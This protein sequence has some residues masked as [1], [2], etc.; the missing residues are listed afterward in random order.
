[1]KLFNYLKS[2]FL[3]KKTENQAS[4]VPK[5]LKIARVFFSIGHGDKNNKGVFDGGCEH[6]DIVEYQYNK[7][8]A[9]L[10]EVEYVLRY[11]RGITGV[12]RE[13]ERLK[14]DL[15]IELHLNSSDNPEAN[16]FEVLY[17]KG[18]KL[19]EAVARDVVIIFKSFF[20]HIKLRRN[21]GLYPVTDENG[22]YSL[23]KIVEHTKKPAIL[24]EGFFL[25]HKNDF[26]SHAQY[27][28]FLRELNQYFIGKEYN[29]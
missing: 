29:V 24:I 6:F 14:T 21:N 3:K 15:S 8:S 19:S 23:A 28:E 5:S 17:L 7:T 1:M 27:S 16:G 20:P 10:A 18:D 9:M 4:N 12:A 26:I 13:L 2:R 22:S 11:G 25:S